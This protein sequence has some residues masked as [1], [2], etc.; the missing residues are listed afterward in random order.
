ML[1]LQY[2]NSVVKNNHINKILNNYKL[3]YSRIVNEI[4]SKINE[5]MKLYLKDILAFLENIEEVAEQK[6]KISEYDKNK[7][8]L[9]FIKQKLKTKTYNEHKMRIGFD[10]L[11]QENALLKLKI[12]S[13]NKKISFLIN[14]NLNN[15]QNAS[16]SQKKIVSNKYYRSMPKLSNSSL[17]PKISKSSSSSIVLNTASI[18]EEENN[19]KS[20]LIL[21]NTTKNNIKSGKNLKIVDKSKKSNQNNEQNKKNINSNKFIKNIGN[22]STKNSNK[23]NIN[24]KI[25]NIKSRNFERSSDKNDDKV[26]Q[27]F[28]HNYNKSNYKNPKNKKKRENKSTELQ[29]NNINI[30][31]P[32]NTF[33]NTFNQSLDLERINLNLNYLDIEKNVN[34][35]FD[36]ELKELEQ[37][38]ANIELLLE[39]LSNDEDNNEGEI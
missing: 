16:I 32:L 1:H 2:Y 37:D 28:N 20:S 24:L 36:L 23:N 33:N 12:N 14:N 7:R 6:H 9:E 21:V 29:L 8:E 18:L 26:S 10:S 27:I 22:K 4:E 38:E 5:M 30:Y 3:K 13:L 17:T 35:V 34:E 15:S 39:Q 11:Q 25:T 31:S 19:N